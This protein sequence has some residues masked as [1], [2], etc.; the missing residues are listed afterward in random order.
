MHQDQSVENPDPTQLVGKN[1]IDL[2][3]EFDFNLLV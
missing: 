2:V 3:M 1:K